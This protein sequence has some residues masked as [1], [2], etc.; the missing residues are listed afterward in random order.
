MYSS[1]QRFHDYI[2]RNYTAMREIPRFHLAGDASALI[3]WRAIQFAS[4]KFTRA[5][6][7]IYR[8]TQFY[9]YII[10]LGNPPDVRVRN[11]NLNNRTTTSSRNNVIVRKLATS[12]GFSGRRGKSLGFTY[13]NFLFVCL[14]TI[15]YSWPQYL[16]RSHSLRVRL[17]M[18]SVFFRGR[19]TSTPA[20]I[21]ELSN[22][23]AHAIA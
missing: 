16:F 1:Y 5:R 22:T 3:L 18:Q 23:Y 21:E 17:I 2:Q 11:K 7:R 15:S 9:T 10:T 4:S 19:P 8:I 13:G 14:Y 20:R 12:S 6:E